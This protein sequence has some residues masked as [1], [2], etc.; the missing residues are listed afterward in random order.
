MLKVILLALISGLAYGQTTLLILG[1]SL[2]AGYG[3]E[4]EE[5]FP[6]LLEK[7]FQKDQSNIKIVSSGVSG[8]TSA[9]GPSRMTWQLKMHPTHVLLALGSNDALRGVKTEE[10]ESNLRKTLEIAKSQNIKIILVGLKA[11][12]NYGPDFSAK[13][14]KIFMTLSKDFKADLLPFLLKDVAGEKSL[15]QNDG[16]HPNAKGHQIVAENLYSALKGKLK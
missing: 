3:V 6:F 15:N 1:D 2:T 4:K 12:P 10:T 16:I 11:P 14:E 7:K 13:F 8:S 5:A 9:S